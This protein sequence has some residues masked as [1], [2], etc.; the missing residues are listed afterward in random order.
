MRFNG[1]N[2]AYTL[3]KITQN[4]PIQAAEELLNDRVATVSTQVS[5]PVCARAATALWSAN[6]TLSNSHIRG[7]LAASGMCL[8][9]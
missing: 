3:G 7:I 9:E 6:P 1:F 5:A 2:D 8:D 4:A